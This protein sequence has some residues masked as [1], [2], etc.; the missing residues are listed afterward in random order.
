MKKLN[1][2]TILNQVIKNWNVDNISSLSAS[3]AFY[4]A[5]AL[6]PVVLICISIAGLF[7]SKEAI[8]NELLA[9]VYKIFG[10]GAQNQIQDMIANAIDPHASFL[11]Q[12]IGLIVLIAG[13]TGVFDALQSGLNSI[14]HVKLRPD[15]KFFEII[16]DRFWSLAL[17]LGVGFLLL[18][19]LVITILIAAII[20]F[21]NG[22]FAA[23]L[24]T[25]IVLNFI[26]SSGIV[27]VLFAMMFKYLPDVKIKWEDVWLGAFFTTLL[28]TLGK[29]LLGIYFRFSNTGSEFGAAASL[30][31]ILIWVY[32]SAQIFFLGAEFTKV[33]AL[34]RGHRVIPNKNALHVITKN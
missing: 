2:L 21:F 11:S 31:L 32:Y 14:W 3:L 25:G 7:F 15:R 23:S 22:Y 19:S 13:A 10:S 29:F 1:V 18:V 33:I 26:I 6:A 24:I 34:R 17:V 20:N 16:K 28:F 8:Q 30:I 5:F 27:M 9:E 12:I 4:T